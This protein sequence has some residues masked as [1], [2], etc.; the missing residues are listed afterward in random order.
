M[1][2]TLVRNKSG[3]FKAREG[4][5]EMASD[6]RR[7]QRS[8]EALV[9]QSL[10]RGEAP[11]PA[12]LCGMGKS[13]SLRLD[14]ALAHGTAG[15]GCAL[16]AAPDTPASPTGA[17]RMPVAA[18]ARTPL[19]HFRRGS[20]SSSGSSSGGGSSGNL[21]A[22]T[23]AAVA[24]GGGCGVV[25]GGV[26][27]GAPRGKRFNVHARRSVRLA[28]DATAAL[29]QTER[30]ERAR[31]VIQALCP[32][33]DV[34]C[35]VPVHTLSGT[36]PE[37]MPVEYLVLV[38]KPFK[39]KG[40]VVLMRGNVF[41]LSVVRHWKLDELS[42]FNEVPLAAATGGSDVGS[43]A[44]SDEAD[45]SRDEDGTAETQT[46]AM[47]PFLLRFNEKQRW[48][49]A[50]ATREART[51]FLST[52]F[53][54]CQ[55]HLRVQPLTRLDYNLFA[56]TA[57]DSSTTT[58]AAAGTASGG[59][60]GGAGASGGNSSGNGEGSQEARGG[61]GTDDGS[62]SDG[63]DDETRGDGGSGDAG[64]GAMTRECEREIL[65]LMQDASVSSDFDTLYGRLAARLA[66]L[67]TQN[68]TLLLEAQTQIDGLLLP[69]TR[70]LQTQLADME[71]WLET[72]DVPLRSA[73]RYIQHIEERNNR[74]ET[75]TMNQ[76]QLLAT[77]N[78]LVARLS[79]DGARETLRTANL[80]DTAALDAVAASAATVRE[81]VTA[82]LDP[83][84]LQL[85]AVQEQLDV[86]RETVRNFS[87][88]LQHFLVELVRGMK[89]DAPAALRRRASPGAG[90]GTGTGTGAGADRPGRARTTA[91]SSSSK[92]AALDLVAGYHAQLDHYAPLIAWLK[93]VDR[94]GYGTLLAECVAAFQGIDKHAVRAYFDELQSR[95]VREPREHQ[96]RLSDILFS[97]SN[98]RLPPDWLARVKARAQ[99]ADGATSPASPRDATTSP[100]KA[101][102]TGDD[103][104]KGGML[105]VDRACTM[106]CRDI[107]G[108]VTEEVRW[109]GATFALS[110]REFGD[111]VNSGQM[112]LLGGE[113]R[114]KLKSLINA[115][116][117]AD[118]FHMLES[119][120]SIEVATHAA[121][122]SSSSSTTSATTGSPGTERRA[123]TSFVEREGSL[124]E[125]ECKQLFNGFIDK[126]AEVLEHTTIALRRVSVAPNFVKLPYFMAAMD[127]ARRSRFGAGGSEADTPSLASLIDI[128]CAKLMGAFLAVIQGVPTAGGVTAALMA[129]AV[130]LSHVVTAV[131][132]AHAAQ[133][134]CAAYRSL[135]ANVER[136]AAAYRST[137]TRLSAHLVKKQFGRLVDYFTGVKEKAL[138]VAADE[139]KFTAR[140]ARQ[141]ALRVVREYG[142]S[143]V[144]RALERTLKSLA[145][146]LS[147]PNRRPSAAVSIFWREFSAL[148]TQKYASI[149]ALMREC[150][151]APLPVPLATL[152]TLVA[153]VWEAYV[154]QHSGGAPG[155]TD[156]DDDSDIEIYDSEMD[157]P[158]AQ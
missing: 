108:A 127:S 95:I 15:A 106:A 71:A 61:A 117:S 8:A 79:F 16:A 17:R 54:L 31:A 119:L 9:A 132:G 100:R 19:R 18:G 28:P 133:L 128:A 69:E 50:T 121:S 42:E 111:L 145:K 60:G 55:A 141:E 123:C 59:G 110:D 102:G 5:G 86:A 94:A 63:G 51:Q 105:T 32:G 151:G 93:A 25:E 87:A 146:K 85:A 157:S 40:R 3:V 39:N 118:P 65:E 56:G 139:V 101:T 36:V 98:K 130:N 138:T 53:S 113:F 27:L 49:F 35:Y 47:F 81:L 26:V 67:E 135:A 148:L 74:M 96:E 99:Q 11:S 62:S 7:H 114:D 126:Q 1:S 89:K 38:V 52:L 137:L 57:G 77:L 75:V 48:I 115:A 155:S 72:F 80:A 131:R 58:A 147:A 23:A 107:L 125:Q 29:A 116:F 91:S 22:L 124:I 33:K 12:M 41:T 82:D 152:E 97:D 70:G 10:T 142:P 103:A 154:Q 109:F 156:S 112:V 4:S 136:S 66:E 129:R 13:P 30:T 76:R 14:V 43:D 150:Y 78:D 44:G 68:I 92:R 140:F 158:S 149:E 2:D 45:A 37:T 104:S 90:T 143:A 20:S 21:E 84:L 88:R 34:R 134:Q 24:G 153:A 6:A 120:G 144:E 46:Q 122:A 83:N 73:R 64:A